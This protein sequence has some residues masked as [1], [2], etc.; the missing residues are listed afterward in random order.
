MK[1]DNGLEKLI[2]DFFE[3]FYYRFPEEAQE[4]GIHRYGYKLVSLRRFEISQWKITLQEFANEINKFKSKRG[5]DKNSDLNILE[6]IVKR[7]FDWISNDAEYKDNPLLY[8]S[9]LFSGLIYPAFGSYA[10]ISIRSRNFTDRVNDIKNVVA[11]A[12]ENLKSCNSIQK[13]LAIQYIDYLSTFIDNFSSFLLGKSDTEKKDEIRL[14]KS[15]S[16]EEL[17]KLKKTCE[18]LSEVDSFCNLEAVL[19]KKSLD[20]FPFENME[21]FLYDSLETLRDKI[22]KKAREIKIS[23]PHLETLANVIEAKQ[24]IDEAKVLELFEIVKNKGQNIF[25]YSNITIDI[26]KMPDE[27]DDLTDS[28]WNY[29][30]FQMLPAGEFDLKPVATILLTSTNNINSIVSNIVENI[31]PGV[32]YLKEVKAK[33]VKG[34]RKN[35]VNHYFKEGWRLYVVREMMNELKKTF[36]NEYELFSM[37]NEYMT[38]LT[39]YLE[40]QSFTGKMKMN[41]LLSAINQNEMVFKKDIFLNQLAEDN[42]K[43]LTGFVGLNF[44]LNEKKYMLRKHKPIELHE[45]LIANGSVFSFSIA[46]KMIG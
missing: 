17:S 10:S 42:G 37:Y 16:L 6:T 41:D 27:T 5:F 30:H 1:T 14:G 3:E 35:F 11:A 15:S 19:K 20:D 7:E 26:R 28:V 29:K 2:E 39:A 18:G 25:G 33:R 32:G 34:V 9:K 44:I 46:K 12:E 22:I 45:R 40:N 36:G 4:R 21:P 23:S 8:I 43:T 24:D 13:S 31:Y 38:L